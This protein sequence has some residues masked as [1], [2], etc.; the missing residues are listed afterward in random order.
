[1]YA[2]IYKQ[3]LTQHAGYHF[4]RD[5]IIKGPRGPL[6]RLIY[7]TKDERG[8]DFWDKSVKKELRGVQRLF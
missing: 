8:T 4:F 3:Q 2:S 5:E 7:A 1:L 6:Y